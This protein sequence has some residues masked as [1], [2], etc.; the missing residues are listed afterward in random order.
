MIDDIM[1]CINAEKDQSANAGFLI[2]V[3]WQY[4]QSIM[5][6]PSHLANID[7]IRR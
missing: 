1:D 7:L 4:W 3:Y 2:E 6:F 5:K